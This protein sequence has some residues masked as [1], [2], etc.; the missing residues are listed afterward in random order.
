MTVP[1]PPVRQPKLLNR[2]YRLVKKLGAGTYGTVYLAKDTHNGD[3]L[4]ALK[5]QIME[6]NPLKKE[7]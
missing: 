2:R 7:G 6:D 3:R 5:T 4:V 1:Q